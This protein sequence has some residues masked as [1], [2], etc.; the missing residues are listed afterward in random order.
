MTEFSMDEANDG[1]YKWLVEYSC[2]D[3][4]DGATSDCGKEAF[5]ATVDDTTN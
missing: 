1:D 3:T 2:D 4:H 5:T